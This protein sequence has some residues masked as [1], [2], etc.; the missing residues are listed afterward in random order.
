MGRR[1]HPKITRSEQARE[2]ITDARRWV[3]QESRD[4]A[5]RSSR[6][7]V[8]AY[9][10]VVRDRT[11]RREDV[12]RAEGSP[13]VI[14]PRS[15]NHL[16][17]ARRG[18][19][20][21][22]RRR[23]RRSRRGRRAQRRCRA[24][25][26]DVAVRGADIGIAVHDGIDDRRVRMNEQLAREVAQHVDTL[27][28]EV[29]TRNEVA[30]SAVTLNPHRAPVSKIDDGART[31]AT[32]DQRGVV[33]RQPVSR[34]DRE[35][36][37]QPSRLELDRGKGRE[38]GEA[39]VTL[40]DPNRE[41]LVAHRDDRSKAHTGRLRDQLTQLLE[42]SPPGSLELLGLNNPEPPDRSGGHGHFEEDIRPVRRKRGFVFSNTG[43]FGGPRRKKS[44][45]RDRCARCPVRDAH[46]RRFPLIN[47]GGHAAPNEP[48]DTR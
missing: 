31:A 36:A 1:G 12:D 11:K 16:L 25:V 24:S 42:H 32:N 9:E 35:H 40:L 28:S 26:L 14:H 6:E 48:G 46:W 33:G 19:G 15:T 18:R 5:S 38:P 4:A 37:R 30:R 47:R 2:Q 8:R 17:L 45:E 44:A 39:D 34:G 21:R 23:R 3:E 13:V 27:S 20:H 41:L 22:P 43:V 10:R 29:H 7:L